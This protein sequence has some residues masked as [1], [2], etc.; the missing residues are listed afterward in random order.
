[1][2]ASVCA[3]LGIHPLVAED[4]VESNQRAKVELVGDHVHAVMFALTRPG[5]TAAHE[6]DLVLGERFLLS[7]HPRAWQ[8]GSAHQVRMGVGPLLARGPDFVL[9]ALLDDIVDDY[10]PVLDALGDEIDEL[11]DQVLA[12]AV[13]ATLERLFRLKR[14]LVGIHHVLLPSREILA[15]LTGREL[16]VIGEPRLLLP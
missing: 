1:V 10:F 12:N 7:V 4:I 8:P 14:E 11:Q 16:A 9:W 6:I 2:V 15:Q 5:P 3:D 13:P